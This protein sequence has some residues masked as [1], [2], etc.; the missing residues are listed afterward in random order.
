MTCTAPSRTGLRNGGFGGEVKWQ[1]KEVV[2]FP[3]ASFK[4]IYPNGD[5]TLQ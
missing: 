5:G 1:V 3:K 2:W 4:K